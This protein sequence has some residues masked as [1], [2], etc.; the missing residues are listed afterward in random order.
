MVFRLLVDLQQTITTAEC[1]MRLISRLR[2]RWKQ[3]MSHQASPP[4]TNPLYQIGDTQL[5]DLPTEIHLEIT[6][7]PSL[8]ALDRLNL[9]CTNHHFYDLIP[10]LSHSDLLE[11]EKLIHRQLVPQSGSSYARPTTFACKDCLRLLPRNKF[12]D[13]MTSNKYSVRGKKADRRFC[14]EC[15]LRKM[16][17]YSGQYVQVEGAAFVLCVDC[18]L[19]KDAADD[20]TEKRRCQ[21]C[22]ELVRHVIFCR[23]V[24]RQQRKEKLEQKA[25][26]EARGARRAN[27][28]PVN[29]HAAADLE[30]LAW[31]R[32]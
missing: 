21:E 26:H 16:A 29:Y 14:L 20:T 6:R 1:R 24:R 15:G 31:L 30:K 5:L 9:K 28:P 3:V 2:R 11:A 18:G 22:W 27:Q 4:R 32:C 7:A 13:I 19:F 25:L 10:P 17:Y 12:S 23:D 8:S